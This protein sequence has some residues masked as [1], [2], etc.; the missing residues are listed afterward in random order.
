MT[1]AALKAAV[2]AAAALR[3]EL[4]RMADPVRAA[5]LRGF[6]KTGP[7]EYGEGDRF[8]GIT[9]PQTRAVARAFRGLPLRDVERLLASAIHEE[10]LCALLILVDAFERADPALRARLADFYLRNAS[11][12]NNWDLVDLSAPNIV[13]EHLLSAPTG[14]QPLLRALADSANLWERRIAIVSTHAFIRRREFRPTLDI[15]RR[16]LRDPHDLIH[17]ACGWMLREVGKRDLAALRGFLGAHAARMPRTAL[18]YAIERMAP[19]ERRHW[20]TAGPERGAGKVR[21]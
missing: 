14:W 3:G 20:M 21:P 16:L 10:R 4:R 17:K 19:G 15:A 11:R 13:G 12:I 8:L 2:P 5:V 18:R 1:S 6:F 9:V 7:G